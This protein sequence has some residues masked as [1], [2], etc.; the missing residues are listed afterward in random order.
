MLNNTY[1]EIWVFILLFDIIYS[2][3]A[4]FTKQMLSYNIQKFLQ[5]IFYFLHTPSLN[6]DLSL[7]VFFLNR[8]TETLY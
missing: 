4:C 5:E 3:I 7:K 2:G 6:P 1:T 8:C